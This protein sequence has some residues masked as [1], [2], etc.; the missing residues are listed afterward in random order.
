MDKI[1]EALKAAGYTEVDQLSRDTFRQG[2]TGLETEPVTDLR[3]SPPGLLKEGN[4]AAIHVLEK[5]GA[6]S[7]YIHVSHGCL[8]IRDVKPA[9]IQAKEDKKTK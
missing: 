6:S 4:F 8:F 3:L 9:K 2:K 5:L 1:I 7:G